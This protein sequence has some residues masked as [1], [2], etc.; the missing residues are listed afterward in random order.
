M[1]WRFWQEDDE[2]AGLAAEDGWRDVDVVVLDRPASTT[3]GA[4][5]PCR[6]EGDPVRVGEQVAL[7][8]TFTHQP[9]T[10]RAI[11]VNGAESDVLGGDQLGDVV[12]GDEVD[13]TQVFRGSSLVVDEDGDWP[14]GSLVVQV[15]RAEQRDEDALVV[16]RVAFGT[17]RPGLR[18]VTSHDD[19]RL[20]PLLE[21]VS[22]EP[23]QGSEEVGLVLRKVPADRFRL[24]DQ[25][26][27]VELP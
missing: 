6:N 4:P 17:A 12:L 20:P 26:T 7:S 11:R 14:E 1:G 24:G 27:H 22:V 5:L 13:L 2:V 3:P 21:V 15:Q 23:G 19:D 16:V 9:T 25:L 18:L 10:I 8:T